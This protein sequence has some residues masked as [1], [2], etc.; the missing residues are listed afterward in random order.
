M[1][2]NTITGRVS[3]AVGFLDLMECHLEGWDSKS[4]SSIF[5]LCGD[6]T[7]DVH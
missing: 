6:F 4:R 2:L 5:V 1:D 3:G 7:T